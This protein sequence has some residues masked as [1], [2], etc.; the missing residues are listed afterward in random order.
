M[1]METPPNRNS[2]FALVITLLVVA[3]IVAVTLRLNTSVRSYSHG[4]ANFRD[5]VTLGFAAASGV[6]LALAVLYQD[7]L[8]NE[9]DSDHERWADPEALSAAFTDLFQGLGC[10]LKILDHSGRIQINRLV[11]EAGNVDLVQ[12]AVLTRLLSQR[13]FGLDPQTVDNL[14]DAVKDW[15]DPDDDITRFGAEKGYYL[16]LATP[17][18]CRNGP[19]SSLEELLL[20]R[21]VTPRL[22]YGDA[23]R[24]GISSYLT[25]YGDGRVNVNTADPLV[26]MALS[27]DMTRSAAERMAAYRKQGGEM[28]ADPQWYLTVPG[29]GDVH[30]PPECITVTSTHFEIVSEARIDRLSSRV[31]AVIERAG[32]TMRILSWKKD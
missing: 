15:L 23:H 20:V 16:S 26:L 21:G 32:R 24:P 31:A 28:L 1:S 30:L 6:R 2:G 17:Y 8:S 18:A 22:F 12:A 3:L 5:G 11:D 13:E 25:V 4:A 29:L 27:R 7:G 19:M 10:N 9:V 14:V